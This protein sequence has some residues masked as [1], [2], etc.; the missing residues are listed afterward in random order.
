MFKNYLFLEFFI[1]LFYVT[2]INVTKKI[3]E[4]RESFITATI[5][6]IH[7][8]RLPFYFLSKLLITPTILK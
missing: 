5:F 8:L 2:I 4:I 7:I 6:R 3:L 1:G